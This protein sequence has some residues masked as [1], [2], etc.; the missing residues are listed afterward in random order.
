MWSL[1]TSRGQRVAL[2]ELPCVLGSDREAA[3]V[4]LPHGSISARHARVEADGDGLVITALDG[5]LLEVDGSTVE[6]ARLAHGESLVLGRVSLRLADDQVRSAAP[7]TRAPEPEAPDDEGGLVMRGQSATASA[8]PRS[9]GKLR[10]KPAAGRKGTA[11]PR[12]RHRTT[13]PLIYSDQSAKRGLLHADLSQL[14]GSVKA[15]MLVV[16]AL[17]AAGLVWGLSE[18]VAAG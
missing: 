15:L 6:Q 13:E 11:A 14:S 17:L 2:R 3:D 5:A 12:E 9:Q 7:A 16:L 8:P 10:A 18:L 4:A 1:V